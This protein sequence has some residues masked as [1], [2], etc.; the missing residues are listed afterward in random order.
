MFDAIVVLCS[1]GLLAFI[2]GLPMAL[3]HR[4]NK[5]DMKQATER[6]LEEYR[7]WE[8][9]GCQGPPPGSPNFRI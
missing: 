6:H 9:A 2:F 3:A 7:E 5:K 4:T 8:E 1:I